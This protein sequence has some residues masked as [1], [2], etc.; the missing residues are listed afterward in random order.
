MRVDVTD[1]ERFKQYLAKTPEVLEKFGGRFLA[2]G[3]TFESAEGVSRARHSIL[4]FPSYE[5]ALDCYHSE[6]YRAARSLREGAADMDILI[7]EGLPGA[8]P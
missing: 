5:A 1:P 4:E 6:G 2:R 3:G 8:A 7:L